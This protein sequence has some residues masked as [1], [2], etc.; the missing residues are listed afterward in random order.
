MR[1]PGPLAATASYGSGCSAG[2]RQLASVVPASVCTRWRWRTRSRRTS[3]PKLERYGET[4]FA[5]LKT[6]RYV[7]RG[8]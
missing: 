3:D 2:R 8:I 7:A 4:L 1:W 6:V 5:V